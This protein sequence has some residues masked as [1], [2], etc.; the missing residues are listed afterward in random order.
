[1]HH[2]INLSSRAKQNTVSLALPFKSKIFLFIS[3]QENK[4]STLEPHSDIS[5]IS[6]LSLVRMKVFISLIVVILAC[7]LQNGYAN[8]PTIVH[9]ENSD[10][11]GYQTDLARVFYGILFAQPPVNNLR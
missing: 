11:L 1:V 9:T 2:H 7:T 5:I 6:R 10:I 3:L 4:N 8:E